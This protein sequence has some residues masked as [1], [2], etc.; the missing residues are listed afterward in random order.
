[1][2]LLDIFPTLV[3]LAGISQNITRCKH[4]DKTP[5]CF[6]GKS[7]MPH[8]NT[9]PIT[10]SKKSFAISQYPRPSATPKKN[11]D[12]PR[13]KDIKIMGYSIKTKRYRYTEWISFNNTE[14]TR[15]WNKI[16]GL[17]LYD[18]VRD[19]EESDNVYMVSTYKHVVKYLSKTL[20]SHVKNCD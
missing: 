2:E 17:E 11:S 12:K 19:P 1:M 10:K 14:F 20:R 13:L 16:Y 4:L 7:L 5:L 6:N 15:N 9:G 18:H 8:I 3:D